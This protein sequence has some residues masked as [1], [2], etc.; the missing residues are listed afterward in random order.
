MSAYTPLGEID[1]TDRGFECI[2]FK[3]L[4]GTDCFLQQSSLIDD[5]EES[6]LLVNPGTSA[7]WLGI[8]DNP[9]HLNRRQVKRLVA[10]LELWIDCGRFAE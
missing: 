1:V 7:V 6:P 2:V 5:D 9:M 3:D 10:I 4:A 8:L